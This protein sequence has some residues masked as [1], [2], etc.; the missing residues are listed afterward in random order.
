MTIKEYLYQ[1]K[2]IDDLINSNIEEVDKLRT[3][4][5]NITV[6]YSDEPHGSGTS[7][8]V[9]NTVVKIADLQNEIND[10]IDELVE[11]KAESSK[12][13]NQIKDLR[14]R[15]V[16]I[17]YY[18]QNKTFEQVAVEMGKSYQWICEL[19]GRALLEIEKIKNA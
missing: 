7:D 16:L 2:D 4:A 17:K 8:K 1:L 18:V 15:T 13:I 9:G 5:T 6:T 10:L 11:I 3:L 19:H 12:I 14:L